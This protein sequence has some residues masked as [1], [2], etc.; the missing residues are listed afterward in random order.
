MNPRFRQHRSSSVATGRVT[1][2]LREDNGRRPSGNASAAGTAPRTDL[3]DICREST[4]QQNSTGVGR[5]RRPGVSPPRRPAQNRRR[6]DAAPATSPFGWRGPTRP[7]C[8]Q[9]RRP[10]RH[11]PAGYFRICH[12]AVTSAPRL[13]RSYWCDAKAKYARAMPSATFAERSWVLA[14]IA[15]PGQLEGLCRSSVPGG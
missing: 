9:R 3:A 2:P 10:D 6:A 14:V 11:R 7:A 8:E 15:T 1:V 5:P 4:K 12:R 13:D